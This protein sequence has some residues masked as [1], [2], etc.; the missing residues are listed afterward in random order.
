MKITIFNA[1]PWGPEGHTHIMAQEFSAGAIEAGA[2][3]QI[4]QLVKQQIKTCNRCGVCFYKTAGKCALKDDMEGLINKFM[5]SDIVVFATPVYIDN[6]TSLMKV[7]IDRLMP[8]LEPHYEKDS[9]GQYRRR[10]RFKDY[11]GFMVISSCAIPGQSNFEVLR[12]FFRR[13]A[14]TMHTEVAGEIYRDA[15]GL[16]LLAGK[17]PRF[18]PAVEQYKKLLRTAGQEFVKTRAIAP[19]TLEKLHEPIIDA[20][21]YV[22]Y[23]NRMWDQMLTKRSMLKVLT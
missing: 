21:E 15:A 4:V 18:R 22:E 14:R 17:E 2:R 23:A 20:D 9:C 11:P 3:I 12:L 8:I 10:G 1:S 16:L 7:F 5:A 19:G 6:V 13:M